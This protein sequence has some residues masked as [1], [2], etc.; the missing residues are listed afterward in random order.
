MSV[1]DELA[2][3]RERSARLVS[4]ALPVVAASA[5]LAFL[6]FSTVGYEPIKRAMDALSFD[7][8]AETFSPHL[9]ATLVAASRVA[10]ALLAAAALL[11]LRSRQAVERVLAN[12]ADDTVGYLRQSRIAVLDAIKAETPTHVGAVLAIIMLGI[13]LRVRVVSQPINYDEAFTFIVYANRPWLIAWANY[14]EPNNHLLHTLLAHVSTSIFGSAVWALRLPALIAGIL[15]IPLSYL[16][17]RRLA[18]RNEAVV[19][20]ALTAV[21]PVLIAY[22]ICARGYTMLVDFFLLAVVCGLDLVASRSRPP[23][24]VFVVSCVLG[25]FTL[26][27]FVYAYGGLVLWLVLAGRRDPANEALRSRTIARYIAWT[28]FFVVLCYM[29]G[30]VTSGLR[31]GIAYA[32]SSAAPSAFMSAVWRQLASVGRDFMRGLPAAMVVALG[33]S[34]ALGVIRLRRATSGSILLLPL[35]A[36]PALTVP[37]QRTLAPARVWVYLLPIFFVYA[38]SG[39]IAAVRWS[40]TQLVQTRPQFI[41]AA[42]VAIALIIGVQSTFRLQSRYTEWNSPQEIY[43]HDDLDEVAGYLKASLASND[44]LTVAPF[45]DFPLEYYLRRH[46]VSISFLRR[47]PAHPARVVVLANDMVRQPLEHVLTTNGYDPKTTQVQLLRRFTYSTLY[48]V[49]PR[50]DER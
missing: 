3:G 49:D 20:S 38:A 6:I 35:V 7:G 15:M 21:T 48:Q 42:A 25:T 8:D 5:A 41:N 13:A 32:H 36:L 11:L 43:A 40:T 29:P 18:G 22:S 50:A 46:G 19:V 34:A 9:H 17:A 4:R 37:L 16:A 10:G 26:P 14:S 24:P 2:P 39:A 1:A 27:T 12:L 23:W 31:A 30:L 47:P 45:I 33:A 28:L 44:A